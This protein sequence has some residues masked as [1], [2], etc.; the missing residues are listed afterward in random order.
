[1][2]YFFGKKLTNHF[3]Q[4]KISSKNKEMIKSARNLAKI[5]N[6]KQDHCFICGSKKTKKEST[7]YGIHYLRCLKCNHVYVDRRISD[8]DITK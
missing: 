7:C 8:T 2:K 1:M 6:L 5:S 3:I 4:A